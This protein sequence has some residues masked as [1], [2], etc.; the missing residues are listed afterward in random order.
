[1][2][3]DPAF[4]FYPGDWISGTLGMNFEEKGAYMELL[5]IQFNKGA[6]SEVMIKRLLNVRYDDVWPSLKDKFNVDTDG[7]LYNG[8]L[9]EEIGK[10]KNYTESR[11]NSR[12]KSDEDNVK[13]YLIKDLESGF[14]KIGSSVNPLRRFSEILN[15]KNPA[16]LP[17]DQ[18][19]YDLV[20]QSGVVKR[21]EESDLHSHFDSKR[22]MG[23]WFNLTQ[24]DILYIKN[25]YYSK[26]TYEQRTENEIENGI[27]NT[28]IVTKGG[29]GG[30]G[31]LMDGKRFDE[32]GEIVFFEDGTFQRLGMEQRI[33]FKAG[34]L[35]PRDVK[36]GITY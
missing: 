12:L 33:A 2:A 1:M 20:W 5:I 8:R 10:R 13:I 30:N 11:R 26:I 28:S 27:K 9:R 35:R 22:V 31:R 16:I 29:Y 34:T 4:L 24:D 15:Q 23:E 21:T 18:R 6:I 7:Q 19:N 17:G 36:R 3:K 32:K 14:H 25:K